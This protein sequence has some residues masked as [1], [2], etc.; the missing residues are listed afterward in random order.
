MVKKFIRDNDILLI[1][2]IYLVFI[3]STDIK[4]IVNYI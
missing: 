4:A 3:V 2:D 1:L